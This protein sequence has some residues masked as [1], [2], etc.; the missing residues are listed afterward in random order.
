MKVFPP[1]R[2]DTVNQCLWRNTGAEDERIFLTPKG[3]QLLHYLV[4][5]AGRLVTQREL[6]G[7]VS[8]GTFIGYGNQDGEDRVNRA[9]RVKLQPDLTVPQCPGQQRRAAV[10]RL[11]NANPRARGSRLAALPSRT[12]VPNSSSSRKPLRRTRRNQWLKS[13]EFGI[14][15]ALRQG[16]GIGTS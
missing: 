16:I 1:F 8:P 11:R 13:M 6:L 9:R 10:G 14:V 4:E 3:F 2:L 12:G 7:A 15:V 5:H